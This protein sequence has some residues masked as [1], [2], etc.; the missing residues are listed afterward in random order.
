MNKQNFLQTGGFPLETDTLDA[1]QTAYGLFNAL[2][3][4]AG[5]KAIIKGCDVVGGTVTDGVVYV[6]GE[7][8]EFKGG[9]AQSTVRIIEETTNKL[10]ENGESKAVLYK[11]YVTFASGTGAMNWS[12][13]KKAGSL[14]ALAGRILPPGTNPQLYSGV[15][16]DIPTGWQLCDGTN[17]TPDLRGQFIVGYNPDDDDYNAIGKT[18]GEKK[19]TL[20]IAEM[21]AHDHG[22]LSGYSGAHS[23]TVPN[24]PVTSG[25]DKP[26]DSNAGEVA[27]GTATTS[28]SGDHRHTIA[29]QGEGEAHE[30]RP[31]YYTLAYIIY[32]GN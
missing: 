14:L 32:T 3:A 19:H 28:Q 22:G 15:I 1:M 29:S 20:S 12:D 17:N 13:F 18:G 5:D 30:N 9:V 7:V 6:N 21:P 16:A 24:V 23:H 27:R 26:F 8:F 31:P 10:F 4:I 25:T 11:R 2:G